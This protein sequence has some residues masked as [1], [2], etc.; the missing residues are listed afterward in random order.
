M[1]LVEAE[2]LAMQTLKQVMEEKVTATNVEL[3]AVSA[4]TGRFRI[5][6]QDEVTAVLARLK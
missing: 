2:T 1:T 5:Y 3:A 4:A 6:H